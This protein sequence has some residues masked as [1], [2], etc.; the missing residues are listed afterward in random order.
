MVD[1]GWDS[2]LRLHGG[3]HYQGWVVGVGSKVPI[4]NISFCFS[5]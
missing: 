2:C 4:C 5:I 1:L 3:E